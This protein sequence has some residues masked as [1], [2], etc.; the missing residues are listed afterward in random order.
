M[1]LKKRNQESKKFENKRSRINQEENEYICFLIHER[2][3]KKNLDPQISSM[4]RE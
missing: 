4:H 3:S 2:G 1:R